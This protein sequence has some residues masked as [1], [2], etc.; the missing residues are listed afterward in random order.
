MP[1]VA[2]ADLAG[3]DEAHLAG[4]EAVVDEQL[5]P[6]TG[7]QQ[8]AVGAQLLGGGHGAVVD[9]VAVLIA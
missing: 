5:R 4:I 8:R 9:G 3:Q 2:V 6:S 1:N 7:Q